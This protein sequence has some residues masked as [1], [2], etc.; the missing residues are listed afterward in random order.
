MAKR[1]FREHRGTYAESMETM[2]AVQ[3]VADIVAHYEN[4]PLTMGYFKRIRI[5]PTTRRGHREPQDEWGVDTYMVVADF[6]GYT[7]QCIGY[8]N[9][10]GY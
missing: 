7:G 1:F 6:D 3:S 8:S 2:K 4:D 5:D 9:F 10:K